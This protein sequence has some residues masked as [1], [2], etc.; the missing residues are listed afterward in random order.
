M[1]PKY[2][3]LREKGSTKTRIKAIDTPSN[4]TKEK[5]KNFQEEGNIKSSRNNNKIEHNLNDNS[6]K[7]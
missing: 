5:R 1:I 3:A 2:I 4:R 7:N 6:K